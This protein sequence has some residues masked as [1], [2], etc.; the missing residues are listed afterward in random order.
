M[1]GRHLEGLNQKAHQ[2]TSGVWQTP[3]GVLTSFLLFVSLGLVEMRRVL[4]SA[5]SVHI[6]RDNYTGRFYGKAKPLKN[7]NP[8]GSLTNTGHETQISRT[9]P[10]LAEVLRFHSGGKFS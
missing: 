7:N 5:G 2:C 8:V 9:L 1:R 10:C 3:D 4:K 6:H